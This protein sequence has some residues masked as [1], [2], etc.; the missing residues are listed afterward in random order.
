MSK[1][2]TLKIDGNVHRA[3]QKPTNPI[4]GGSSEFYV[5][6]LHFSFHM[7][8]NNNVMYRYYG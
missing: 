3:P 7:N 6:Y 1:N 4:S 5:H 2:T 8:D